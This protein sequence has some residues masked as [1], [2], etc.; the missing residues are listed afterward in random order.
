MD[1]KGKAARELGLLPPALLASLK[2]GSVWTVADRLITFPE[3]RIPG[4]PERD[5]HATRRVIVMQEQQ[6]CA[7]ADR[8]TVLAVPC[9]TQVR[10]A[11]AGDLRWSNVDG[12]DAPEFVVFATLIQPFLKS[13]FQVCKG[14]IPVERL[15]ELR[16]TLLQNMG[17]LPSA[18]FP[19]PPRGTPQ[20]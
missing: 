1:P 13:D 6:L 19:M 20:P 17:V 7:A 14:L 18:R 12:F 16:A 4:T 15:T 9:S 8:K 3:T 10:R 5:M 11:G 2:P